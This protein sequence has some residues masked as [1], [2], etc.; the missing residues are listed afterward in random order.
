MLTEERRVR[1]REVTDERGFIAVRDLSALF[2]VSEMTVRRDLDALEREGRLRRTHGGVVSL[3]AVPN[4]PYY[5]R[6]RSAVAEKRAIG[7]AAAALVRDGE[8]ILLTAGTT[9]AVMAQA[10]VGRQN[11]TVVTNAYSIIPMLANVP[12]IRLIVTGGEA[13]HQAG[14]LVGPLAEQVI[15]Q[16]RVDRA[17]LGATAIDVETGISNGDLDE[18]AFQRAVLRSARAIYVLAD[19]TKFG[20]FSF[21][22]VGPLS[23]A[24]AIVTDTGLDAA[25]REAYTAQGACLIVR[26]VSAGK[27]EQPA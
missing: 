7:Q 4:A 20:K 15:D 1:I 14:S 18:A 17:F 19:H 24:D 16:L 27:A 3:R 26:P 25:A 5:D 9:I 8:T 6:M 11:V 13:R 2:S 21:A 12:G 10:L 22:H 23:M